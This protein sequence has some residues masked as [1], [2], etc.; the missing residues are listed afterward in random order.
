MV[1]IHSEHAI[2]YLKGQFQSLK[3]LHVKIQDETCRTCMSSAY[4]NCHPQDSSRIIISV[5]FPCLMS[6]LQLHKH[7][8]SRYM[9]LFVCFYL[10]QFHFRVKSSSQ[11]VRVKEH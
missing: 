4:A 8:H 11:E 3:G 5:S 1:C 10:S 2:G 6:V 7:C 9:G